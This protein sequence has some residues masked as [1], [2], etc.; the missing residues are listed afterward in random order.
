MYLEDSF[1]K[2]LLDNLYDGV[3]FVDVERSIIYWNRGAERLT[4]YGGDEVIGHYCR[5]N[6]LEHVDD[7]GSR[8]CES[9]LC[10]W[11]PIL[12]VGVSRGGVGDFL[13]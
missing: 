3:Y 4:G 1:Y 10:P 6:I 5:E 11:G 13:T 2:A 12:S 8:L 7:M 9:D